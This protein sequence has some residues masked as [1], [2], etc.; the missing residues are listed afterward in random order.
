[1]SL[2][3]AI[4]PEIQQ[5]LERGVRRLLDLGSAR[6]I[7]ELLLEL[8]AHDVDATAPSRRELWRPPVARSFAGHRRGSVS[9]AAAV[10]GA[11]DPPVGSMKARPGNGPR[12]NRPPLRL[13]DPQELARLA[14][15][16]NLPG[17]EAEGGALVDLARDLASPPA[18][19]ERDTWGRKFQT[20]VWIFIYFTKYEPHASLNHMQKACFPPFSR[21]RGSIEANP[22]KKP[23]FLIAGVS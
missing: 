2:S 12:H 4:D 19:E 20:A 1:M 16:L 10:A 15:Q 9:P 3:P 23:M 18:G 13:V 21:I 5:R 8:G 11:D 22:D 7:G 6:V 14:A 17:D